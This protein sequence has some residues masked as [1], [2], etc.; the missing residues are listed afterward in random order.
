MR[1]EIASPSPQE[2][3]V[4]T[5]A[6]RDDEFPAAAELFF[7][8]L[9]DLAARH[10]MPAPHRDIELVAKG[11]AYVARTGAFRVATIDE[12]IVALACAILRGPWW[13]LSGF[14]TD[15]SLRLRGIGGPLLRE[16]W[17]EGGT[18]GARVFSVWASIDGPAIAS[19]LKLGMLPG[20]QL[21]AF[22]GAASRTPATSLRAEPLSPER[23]AELDRDLV[24]ARRDG[25]H[26]YW[27][28][29]DGARG[30]VVL[31]GD[32]LVGYYYAHDGTVGP[33]GWTRD[34]LGGSV[35]ALAIADAAADGKEVQ[36]TVPGSNHVALR[37]ALASGLRLVRQSHLLRTEPIGRMERYIPSGPLLF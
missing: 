4:R 15:P 13:F 31:S 32:R 25:D 20:T 16:V 27:L 6:I 21:F 37:F 7:G 34:Q 9:A 19:Y 18:R 11:Y 2:R 3:R 35:L 30:R 17:D 26:A 14:W 1:N 36:L 23:V 33:V 12:R 24:G 8:S 29:R 10:N 22:A 5:R 28:D